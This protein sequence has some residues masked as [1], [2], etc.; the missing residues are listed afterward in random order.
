MLALR[1]EGFVWRAMVGIAAI[2]RAHWTAF[3]MSSVLIPI[4]YRHR[5]RRAGAC[6]RCNVPLAFPTHY[7]VILFIAYEGVAFGTIAFG[8]VRHNR[9]WLLIGWPLAL[10]AALI[11]QGAILRAFPPKL[12]PYGEG[13]TWL[14]LT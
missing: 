7:R 2:S 12:R 6:P 13:N 1:G 10:I 8:Y 11:V 4:A 5:I 9:G 3:A 14:K